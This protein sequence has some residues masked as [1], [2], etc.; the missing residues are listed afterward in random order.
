MDW[1]YYYYIPKKGKS[2]KMQSSVTSLWTFIKG[3]S[4]SDVT[5]NLFLWKLNGLMCTKTFI[6][7]SVCITFQRCYEHLGAAAGRSCSPLAN[8]HCWLHVIVSCGIESAGLIDDQ[9]TVIVL[10]PSP[11]ATKVRVHHFF[12]VRQCDEG[13]IKFFG[14]G[15]GMGIS[16]AEQ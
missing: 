2:V 8:V 4:F 12:D 1:T 7:W 13:L 9:H 15:I 11:L 6:E 3:A 5:Q 16:V 14:C 10:I